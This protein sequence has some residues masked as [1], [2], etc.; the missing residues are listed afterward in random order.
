MSSAATVTDNCS[1]LFI[2]FYSILFNHNLLPCAIA[3]AHNVQALGWS[4]KPIAVCIVASL[5]GYSAVVGYAF[6]ACAI[7]LFDV[8]L[9]PYFC[10]TIFLCTA[11]GHIEFTFRTRTTVKIII[12]Q[13]ERFRH[14]GVN[15]L[16]TTGRKC[17][18]TNSL[19]A[20]NSRTSISWNDL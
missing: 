14:V 11:L 12:L 18:I 4:C 20:G 13:W 19:Q 8:E 5:L 7:H 1:I 3:I 2:I 15:D 10:L 17:V 9:F 16:S 6:N